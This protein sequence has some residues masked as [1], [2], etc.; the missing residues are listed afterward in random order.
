MS[1]LCEVSSDCDLYFKCFLDRT[2]GHCKCSKGTCQQR[3]VKKHHHKEKQTK[4]SFTKNCKKFKITHKESGI[5]ID[6]TGKKKVD[7]KQKRKCIKKTK[8]SKHTLDEN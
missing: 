5:G 6:H 3:R 7:W 4:K 2:G 1:G 8:N